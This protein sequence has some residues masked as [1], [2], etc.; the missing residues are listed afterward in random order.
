MTRRAF[1]LRLEDTQGTA[2]RQYSTGGLS[3]YDSALRS[4]FEYIDL[5]TTF[6]ETFL[7]TDPVGYDTVSMY[8]IPDDVNSAALHSGTL[9]AY[10][11]V[12]STSGYPATNLDGTRVV[13]L[14]YSGSAVPMYNGP[15]DRAYTTDRGLLSG[16]W[17]YY[18]LFARYQDSGNTIWVR[19]AVSAVLVP[20]PFG[21]PDRLWAMIPE[22]YRRLDSE[23][24]GMYVNDGI[25]QRFIKVLGYMVDIQ[26][27]YAMTLGSLW[28][29]S[30]VP[31]AILNYLGDHIGISSE[32]APGQKRYRKV[33][34]NAFHL[35]K[36]SGT[37]EGI[38]GLVAA[39]T[40]YPTDSYV[41]KN[42]LLSNADAAQV[43]GSAG[44][45]TAW[46]NCTLTPT[47][48]SGVPSPQNTTSVPAT[49]GNAGPQPP[50]G[51]NAY[52]LKVTASAANPTF[53]YGASG[54]FS[55]GLAIPVIAAHSYVFTLDAAAP[56]GT[57]NLTM[58][59]KWYKI[60]TTVPS[61]FSLISTTTDTAQTIATTRKRYGPVTTITAPA[62]AVFCVPTVTTSNAS[63]DS[64]FDSF[65]FHDAAWAPEE[66]PA[67]AALG[68]D[69]SFEDARKIF[70]NI[71]PQ[72]TNFVQNSGCKS[73]YTGGWTTTIP[74]IYELLPIAY[75]TYDDLLR[76]PVARKSLT[77]NVALI[78]T[79]R[80]HKITNGQTV[81]ITAV[82]ATFNGT[83]T[84][85]SVPTS[86]TFTYALVHA[87]VAD[88]AASGYVS[89]G[90][91]VSYDDLLA[92]YDTFATTATFSVD[93]TNHWLLLDSHGS[94][95]PYLSQLS[96]AFFPIPQ[97]APISARVQA[98]ANTG[99]GTNMLLRFKWFSKADPAFEMRGAVASPFYRLN[100]SWQ[101][102][103]LVNILPPVGV[104]YGRLVIE[105][106]NSTTAHQ[107]LLRQFLVE[108]AQ[109][110][111]A[112]FDGD[113]TEG[114]FGD[115][116][117][118][119][120]A[121]QSFS[122]YFMQKNAMIAGYSG[123][124]RVSSLM[125]TIIPPDRTYAVNTPF[126]TPSLLS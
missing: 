58:A 107:E 125:P 68:P 25:L 49:V 38:R 1:A 103:E 108:P 97:I 33:L 28:D 48:F 123:N 23:N 27:T 34:A 71:F 77:S 93:T 21:Y 42:L 26:R 99:T 106:T 9:D 41:G 17:Y 10:A 57:P 94:V 19:V 37:L 121:N 102:V 13:T 89:P 43:G 126:S 14:D 63:G 70:V 29:A 101:D 35:R 65:C 118:I 74:T 40:G 44:G 104:N 64:Y 111:G 119:G 113:T 18:G 59:F 91:E 75:A 66:F 115:F 114:E 3:P 52:S 12:R 55:P 116:S 83:Y 98:M 109:F 4:D 124:D 112:Y 46:S 53:G 84:V 7:T 85:T 122:V 81:T 20:F 100:G 95:A 60:D 30:S 117:F 88:V 54:S 82:D 69:T 31:A 47:L 110:P 76:T 8:F 120:T 56:T 96:S 6:D 16:R 5:P 87:D 11:I 24:V 86:T 67:L 92:G 62:N 15:G 36:L 51:V 80:A 78:T 105:T 79:T 61:G 45:W 73:S 39:M 50:G 2:L 22:Y 90:S 32:T 72:R